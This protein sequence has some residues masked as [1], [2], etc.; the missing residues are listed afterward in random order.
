MTCKHAS[1]SYYAACISVFFP[2]CPPTQ[3]PL[4]L[5]GPEERLVHRAGRSDLL[6]EGRVHHPV[7]LGPE[8][9]RRHVGLSR[10]GPVR[11]VPRAAG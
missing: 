8:V 2:L 3:K 6:R 5:R 10:M 9:P 4:R 1:D 11:D 7:H